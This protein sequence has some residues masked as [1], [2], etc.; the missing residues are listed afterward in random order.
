VTHICPRAAGCIDEDAI[1]H[2]A[3]RRAEILDAILRLDAQAQ[4]VAAI[5]ERRG[6]NFRCSR[7]HHCRQ[8]SP[9]FEL[10]DSCSHQGVSRHRVGTVGLT[11]DRENI[12]PCAREKHRR[13]CPGASRSDDHR[14]VV[15]LEMT[16]LIH[17][18]CSVSGGRATQAEIQVRGKVRGILPG[19][20]DER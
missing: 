11:F 20:V 13:S 15:R 10:K 16:R 18:N 5:V 2:G 17:V 9:S 3:P 19:P 8:Q 6:A 4:R 1:Q 14:I 12:H 7:G